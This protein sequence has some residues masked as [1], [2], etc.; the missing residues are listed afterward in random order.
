MT[1]K[2]R[3]SDEASEEMGKIN[4]WEKKSVRKNGYLSI[5]WESAGVAP[6]A[7]TEQNT[8]TAWDRGAVNTAK[9]GQTD[10][11]KEGVDGTVRRARE[12]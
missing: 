1:E 3:L 10:R 2:E 9:A 5:G 12:G 4:F 8:A 11:Q 7:M 6:V